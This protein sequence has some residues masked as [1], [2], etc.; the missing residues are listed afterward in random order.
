MYSR[1]LVALEHSPSD[2]SILAHVRSLARVCG[3]ALVLIHVADG[4]VARNIAELELRESKEMREDRVY[5]DRIAAELNGDGFATES[6][7]ATGDPAIEIAAAAQRERCTLIAMSTHGH[8]F[9][10]DL[11][12][13]SVANEVRHRS[14]VPVLLVR[15]QHSDGNDAC[16]PT[17]AS[18][19]EEPA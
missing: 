8:R 15:A 12:R 2:T 7:L 16:S 6:V 13:G 14:L 10:A 19:T 3:S 9:L 5:L 4:W 17:A 11:W 1:I 18:P